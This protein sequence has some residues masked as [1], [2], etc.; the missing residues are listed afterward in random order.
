MKETTSAGNMSQ[1]VLMMDSATSFSEL[2]RHLAKFI[3]E[4]PVINGNVRRDINLCPYWRMPGKTEGNLNFTSY[5]IST[6]LCPPP[7]SGRA[8]LPRGELKGGEG[9]LW[10]VLSR[11][12][13]RPFKDDTEHLAFHHINMGNHKSCLA[14]TFDHR[15]FDA[16]GAESFLRLFQQYLESGGTSISSDIPLTGPAHLSDWMKKFLAGRNVNRKIMSLSEQPLAALPLPDG[17]KKAF[18]YRLIRFNEQETQTIYDNAYRTAG[19]LMELPYM[20]SII[21]QA[22]NGLFQKRKIEQVSYLASVSIDMRSSQD[23]KQE[24]FF[25]HVSYLFF[26]AGSSIVNSRK[27]LVNSIKMQMYEQVKAGV[28]RDL[29]EAS[30]LTRIA[31]LA[32]FN[33]V[34]SGPFKGKIAT[35]IF[36]HVSK[37]PLSTE[38]MGAKIEDVFHMPR[39][40]VPPGLGFFSNYFNGRLNLVI[41][42]LDGLLSD[43]ELDVLEKEIK[44]RMVDS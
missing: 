13:N 41:S 21:M 8:D 31:P 5:E 20:L 17:K 22:V 10:T 27:E 7:E 15:L 16:R 44:D 25:N 12:A 32:L 24:M 40:P 2:Q 6:P 33:K 30:H 3:S 36:S 37:N 9:D 23:I 1:V 26:Q 28:P 4:F 35:F 29:M 34:I 43:D 11:C 42:Y 38:F 19:Y 18:R 14:M 39:V